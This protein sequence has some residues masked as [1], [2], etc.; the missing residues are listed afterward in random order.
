M[1]DKDE[2]IKYLSLMQQEVITHPE[3]VN[4]M[5]EPRY[6]DCDLDKKTVTAE[7]V[8][9]PWEAN[10]VGILHGGVICTMLDHGA[11]AAVSALVGEWCPT[12]DMDVHFLRQGHIGE[13]L[14][15]VGEILHL[16]R[17]A[18]HAEARL[19]DKSS[20]KMIASCLATYLIPDNK[21]E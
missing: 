5:M 9:K 13:T 18:I 10:R 4:G 15:V 12:M 8:V 11:G 21:S 6:I 17:R 3:T 1:R 14:T 16:G 2:M 20:G 19:Y 7:Y